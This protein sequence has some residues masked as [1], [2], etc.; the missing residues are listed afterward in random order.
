MEEEQSSSKN[1]IHYDKRAIL[2][3]LKSKEK[4]QFGTTTIIR[5][6]D[7]MNSNTEMYVLK[8]KLNNIPFI[9]VV[10][11]E[12][13]RERYCINKY[14]NGD[15]YLVYYSNNFRNKQTKIRNE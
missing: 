2:K 12:F 11:Y 13:K 9:V 8:N 6:G 5:L 10:N 15:E 3:K 14:Q 4:Y 1:K 7:D